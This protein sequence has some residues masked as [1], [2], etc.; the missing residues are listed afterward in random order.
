MS[1]KEELKEQILR[2]T[3][4]YYQEAHAK[5][6]DFVPGKTKVNYGGRYFDDREMV[7]L[8][9]ASLDF[10][11]TAGPWAHRFEVGL[12]KWLGVTYCSLCNSGSS[13]NLLAF[14][15]LTAHELGDRAIKRGDEVITVAAGF[16]TTVS[17]ILQ[18]HAVPVFVD[19]RIEDSNID[20]TQL[21]AALSPK[22]DIV[23][24]T[25]S[26]DRAIDAFAVGAVHYL[27]KPVTTDA[28]RE[29][30]ARIAE[31]WSKKRPLFTVKV[32]RALCSEFLESVV[33]IS[34]RD[35]AVEIALA[36]GETFIVNCGSSELLPQLDERFLK[37]RRGFLV[38]MEYIA[39]MGAEGCTLRNGEEVLFSRK[40]RISIREA[41]NRWVFSRLAERR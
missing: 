36:S 14:S 34:S 28:I 4:E 1:K 25:T 13:A 27:V 10:W 5:A 26:R 22:T 40:E 12:A 23:F 15:A 17:A 39:N 24:V 21:E 3:R 30:F 9:D 38:N 41:Y 2:L 20:V 37:L 18:Y 11:L 32:G 31:K 7:N 35:H 16:P 19:M 33:S 6:Q 29:A 8:V